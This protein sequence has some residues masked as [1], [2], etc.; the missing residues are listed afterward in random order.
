MRLSKNFVLTEINR[1]N[2]AKRNG[3]REG[4]GGG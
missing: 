1:S 3:E 4:G 2:K